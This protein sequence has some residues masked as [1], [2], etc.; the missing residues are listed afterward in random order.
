MNKKIKVKNSEKKVTFVVDKGDLSG[1]APEVVGDTQILVECDKADGTGKEFV[2]V[3]AATANTKFFDPATVVKVK[4]IIKNA[5]AYAGFDKFECKKADDTAFSTAVAFTAVAEGTDALTKIA[6]F[7][8]PA[9]DCKVIG[10]LKKLVTP[11][12]KSVKINNHE[13]LLANIGTATVVGL[14]KIDANNVATAITKMTI[15]VGGVDK[16]LTYNADAAKSDFTLDFSAC[17][18]LTTDKELK[19]TVKA[20]DGMWLALPQFAIKVKK[21]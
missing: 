21:A 9:E 5:K 1:T 6:T 16:E 18:E 4:F 7:P 12:F 17:T 19:V 20:K 11:T 8:M 13:I 10:S 2:D 3:T 15:T 14:D